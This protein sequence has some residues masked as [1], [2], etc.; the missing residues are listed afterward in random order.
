METTPL[1]DHWLV[2]AVGTLGEGRWARSVDE[3]D[4]VVFTLGDASVGEW[5]ATV[6]IV[7][8]SEADWPSD[9]PFDAATLAGP[10]ID[11]LASG[12][13]IRLAQATNPDR[14]LAHVD[15]KVEAALPG[16]PVSAEMWLDIAPRL[17]L[18]A[19]AAGAD[20][21]ELGCFLDSIG[22]LLDGIPA[23]DSTVPETVNTDGL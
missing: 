1:S 5:P 7:A 19:A 3:P 4:A 12:A 23:G 15:I 16:S 20:L 18:A 6:S 2:Q 13:T 14:A 10:S 21:Y 8:V 22:D 17:H 11:E 9:Q